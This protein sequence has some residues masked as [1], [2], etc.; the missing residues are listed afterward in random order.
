M[1][2]GLYAQ[3]CHRKDISIQCFQKAYARCATYSEM[4]MVA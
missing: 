2:Y 4:N 1:E 3:S